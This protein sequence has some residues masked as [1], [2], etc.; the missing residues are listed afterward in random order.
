MILKK[1][2]MQKIPY[3][4]IVGNL[5]YNQ[6]CTRLDIALVVGVLGYMLTYWKSRLEIIK[7]HDSNFA[8]C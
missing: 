8:R 2:K 3:A 7:Y 4:S 5:M 1:N 6:I